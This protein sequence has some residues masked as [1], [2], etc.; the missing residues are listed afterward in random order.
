MRGMPFLYRDTI[1]LQM[2]DMKNRI[3]LADLFVVL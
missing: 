2:G 1:F 3:I